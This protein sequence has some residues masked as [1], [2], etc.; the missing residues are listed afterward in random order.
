MP[1]QAGTFS[2]TVQVKDSS[3]QTTSAS[4]SI[5]IAVPST[6]VISGVS[7]S[8]GPI[9]G[10]TNV[11]ISGAN[12]AAGA[13][14]TF[15]GMVANSVVVNSSTQIQAMTPSHLA[16]SVGVMVAENGQS[17]PSGASFTYNSLSPTIGAVSPNN[18]PTVGGTS[19]TIG[20]TNFLAGAL[21]LF[22]TV[23]ATNVSVVSATQIQAVTPA[24]AAG[25]ANVT[26]QDPG[27]LNAALSG[28]FTYNTS[29]S[30]PPTISGISPT[31]GAPGTQ[32]TITGAN[33]TSADTVSFGANPASAT[34]VNASQLTTTVPSIA[35]GTYSVTVTDPDPASVTFNSF[36]VSPAPKGQSLL[37]GA[38]VTGCGAINMSVPSG[39]SLL[40]ADGFEGGNL[41]DQSAEGLGNGAVS[42]AKGHSGSCSIS[43]NVSYDQAGPQW[44]YLQGHSGSFTSI[45]LSYWEYVD[46]QAT[47][48]DEYQ[49]GDLW[50]SQNGG[51]AQE[52]AVGFLGQSFNATSAP[53]T[54]DPQNGVS[55]GVNPPTTYGQTVSMAGGTWHQYEIEWTPGNNGGCSVQV[56]RDSSLLASGSGLNCNGTVNMT[57]AQVQAGGQYTKLLW[58]NNGNP[59]PSGACTT[60]GNGFG[61]EYQGGGASFSA[62]AAL[63]GPIVPSFNRYIDDVIVMKQ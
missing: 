55:N 63:C 42:C 41:C 10:G 29:Q 23:P 48:N 37:S 38:T 31:S 1:S 45:Y 30:G 19:V 33:F 13:T 60:L 17:S 18:G 59:P 56:Y 25:P 28:G 5:N 51:F 4:F 53:M 9:S 35:A 6:P 20:G 32:V 2:F 57:G 58:T 39:W 12:F 47:F 14:V 15:G 36:V 27:N 40:A 24:N 34:L 11:T 26:V 7:P 8:S 3:N 54:F 43:T 62:I 52:I 61:S 22:G 46:P 49:V 50:Q 16:G 21:V 44:L